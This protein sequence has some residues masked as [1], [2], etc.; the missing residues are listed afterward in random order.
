MTPSTTSLYRQVAAEGATYIGLLT[1]VLDSLAED[2]RL[3]GLAAASRDIPARCAASNH[4]FLLLAHL[5]SWATDLDE[6]ALKASLLTFYSYVRST[7]TTL[8]AHTTEQPFLDLAVHVTELRITWQTKEASLRQGHSVVDS[9]P[10]TRHPASVH[11][12]S[13]QVTASHPADPE[14]AQPRTL[15]WSA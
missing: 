1:V 5:E 10:A 12:A 11:S 3:A 6:P 9:P 15:R 8:Q 2:L 4:A 7:L 14:P 13:V